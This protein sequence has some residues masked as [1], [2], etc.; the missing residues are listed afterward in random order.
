M[1][2]YAFLHAWRLSG[3]PVKLVQKCFFFSTVILLKTRL[4]L[5]MREH[6]VQYRFASSVDLNHPHRL[7]ILHDIV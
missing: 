1:R 5:D 4:P 3:S 6:C 2:I 7:I